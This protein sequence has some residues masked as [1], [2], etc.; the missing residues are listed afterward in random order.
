M[1]SLGKDFEKKF[2][3]GSEFEQKMKDLGDEMKEKY[4]PDSDFAKKVKEK[5][6]EVKAKAKDGVKA[7]T[8]NRNRKISELEAQVAKLMEQIEAL[9]AQGDGEKDRD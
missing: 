1:E 6:A 8:G 9:K 3:P 5:A 2:G 4:G 7:G